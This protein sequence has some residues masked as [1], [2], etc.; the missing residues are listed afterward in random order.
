MI[1]ARRVKLFSNWFAIYMR[2]RM[3][4]AFNRLVVTPFTPKPGHSVLLLCNHFSWWDGLWGNYLAYWHLNKDLYIMMQEDHLQKRM[5]LN[6]FGGFSINRSSREMVKSLQ[7]AAGLLNDPQNLVVVFPQ[8]ELISNHT[9][10]IKVEKGIERLIKNIK[11]PC[12]IVYNCALI[13][14]FESLKPSVFFHLF[15]CGVAG[16]VP[17]DELVTQINTFHQQALKAQIQVEH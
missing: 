8:G 7:Y 3:R 10:E 1:P 12:Q 11:G 14:Y 5:L 13:D 4:K 9:T 17:F 16:E 6:L 15:D 2:Y